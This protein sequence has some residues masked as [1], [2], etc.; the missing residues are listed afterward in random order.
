[1]PLWS[2]IAASITAA[3]GST[4]VCDNKQ[5]SGGGCINS[6]FTVSDHQQRYFVKLNN[7]QLFD[8]FEAE[9][10]GLNQ[11]AAS[12]S[13]R[14]PAVICAGI[15]GNQSYLVLQHLNFIHG[16]D[17]SHQQ[18]AF[19]LAQMHK[20]YQQQFGWVRDNTIGTTPQH[21]KQTSNW[22]EFWRSERLGF[23]LQLAASNGY[24]GQL[25]KLGDQ[26]ISDLDYFFAGYSP[27]ASLLHG[28]LWSGNYA[29]VADGCPIIFDPAVYYGDREADI[30]MTELFG[31]FNRQF[32]HAYQEA[33]PLDDGYQVRKSLYNLYHL[34]NHLNLFGGGYLGQAEAMLDRL[35][36]EIR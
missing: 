2:D 34:L 36:V 18:L 15:S 10:A 8:M 28:D 29:I 19:D 24:A 20:H 1:M 7:A 32:Y 31:G 12:N 3:T 27:Q 23:Q 35:L 5:A 21:N 22:I 26:L 14:V 13:I 33:F 9:A 25:Q 4:F 11:I 6:T 17:R 16:D 30:A